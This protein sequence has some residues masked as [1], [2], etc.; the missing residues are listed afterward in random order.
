M[1][2]EVITRDEVAPADDEARLRAAEQLV[3]RERDE[4]GAG[5]DGVANRGLCG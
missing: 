1:L 5:R 3:A 2:Y 4:V